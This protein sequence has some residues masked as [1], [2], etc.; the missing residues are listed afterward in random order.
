M[1]FPLKAPPDAE[2]QLHPP[3]P[4]AGARRIRRARHNPCRR[5]GPRAWAHGPVAGGGARPRHRGARQ[6]LARARGPRPGEGRG[7]HRRR[8]LRFAKLGRSP[9]HDRCGESRAG[10]PLRRAGEHRAPLHRGRRRPG[11]GGRRRHQAVHGAD[12]GAR[13]RAAGADRR[14]GDAHRRRG[15][16]HPRLARSARAE[17]TAARSRHRQ[18]GRARPSNQDAGGAPLRHRRPGRHLARRGDGAR[19]HRHGDRHRAPRRRGDRPA[20]H[21]HRRAVLAHHAYRA[22]RPERRR[23]RG[24]AAAGRADHGQQ[25]RRPAHRRNSRK[26]AGAAR[27]RRAASGRAHLAQPA[28][29]GRLRRSRPLHDSQAAGEAG[30][31]P[32]LRTLADRLPDP[33]AVRPEDQG[34]RPHHLRPLRQSE[35]AAVRLFRQHRPLRPRGRCAPHRRRAGIR[36]SR[37][38]CPHPA[39]L[40]PAGRSLD[41]GGRAAVQ[42]DAHRDRPPPPRHPGAAGLGGESAGLGRLAAHRLGPDPSRRAADPVGRQRPAAPGALA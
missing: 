6:P 24:R 35:R 27:L 20:E 40:D 28:E 17:S 34:F 8:S 12:P 36:R 29:V 11:R 15:A 31:H 9:G 19:R 14:R 42:G 10:T 4:L 18:A 39:R 38:P 37:Q 26:T 5:R 3:R 22:W 7:G 25:P 21:R 30:R 2:P 16:R 23:D 32:D 33:R 1:S 13:R 41:E